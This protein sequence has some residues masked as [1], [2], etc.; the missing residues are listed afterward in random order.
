[1]DN[2]DTIEYIKSMFEEDLFTLIFPDDGK[3]ES[4]QAILDQLGDAAIGSG[5]GR[6]QENGKIVYGV[7]INK[8][9]LNKQ[10][11]KNDGSMQSE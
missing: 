4:A 8:I 7:L 3:Y 9:V 2:K 11:D 6:F 1:M 10:E 5:I